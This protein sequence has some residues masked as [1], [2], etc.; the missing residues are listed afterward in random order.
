M[1]GTAEASP[2]PCATDGGIKDGA[3]HH[4][5]AILALR[6]DH[7]AKAG[8]G[9][10]EGADSL[11]WPESAACFSVARC[12]VRYEIDVD[13]CHQLVCVSLLLIV[14]HLLKIGEL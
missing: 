7:T 5:A 13:A 14:L 4:W 8:I 9:P 12:G 11:P 6:R 2:L 1:R 3:A 10:Q